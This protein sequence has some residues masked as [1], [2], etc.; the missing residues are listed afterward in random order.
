MAGHEVLDNGVGRARWRVWG[1]SVT[2]LVT[3]ADVLEGASGILEEEIAATDAACN[4]FFPD[5]ELSRLNQSAGV[6]TPVGATL[7]DD[8]SMALAAAAIT[9]GAV[10]PT[11]GGSLISLGYDRDFDELEAAGPSAAPP[12]GQPAPGWHAVT[13]DPSTRTV[14]I[15]VG[16]VVDLGSTAKARCADRAAE[17]IAA[18]TGSGTLVDLGGDL[19]VVGALPPGGWQVAVVD[20]ARAELV[21]DPRCVVSVIAGG[22]ASS[23][24]AVRTWSR[25]GRRL[26]HVVDPATGWPAEPVWRT[27]TVAAE[28]CTMANA[29]ATASIVWG[30][31]A[32]FHV[33]QLELAARF[34]RPGGDVIEV[35]DWPRVAALSASMAP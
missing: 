7:L 25:G 27:V 4:R 20:D 34:V 3:Q 8:L 23:S 10:D 31:D 26:H 15:P 9:D 35:G 12:L 6:P 33:P 13:L 29:L 22:L 18:E 16:T 24:T 11:I 32:L 5:S 19:R 14:T 21:S 30:E 17:R 2:L 28:T 1:T